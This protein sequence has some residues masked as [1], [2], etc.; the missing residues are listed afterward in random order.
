M[1]NIFEETAANIIE[2]AKNEGIDSVENVI[3]ESLKRFYQ[4]GLEK[5]Y[6]S[7]WP[8]VL[9]NEVEGKSENFATE[10]ENPFDVDNDDLASEYLTEV[11]FPA[12]ER[13]IFSTA[14]TNDLSEYETYADFKKAHGE[15]EP[16]LE[17]LPNLLYV[18]NRYSDEDMHMQYNF[19]KCLNDCWNGLKEGKRIEDI[20]FE[21][22]E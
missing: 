11:L 5:G 10:Y 1:K 17:E 9:V 12:I 6:K 7:A 4:D 8:W 21:T 15:I 20:L 13:T 19:D 16:A 3:S 14:M 2:V 22:E 18:H